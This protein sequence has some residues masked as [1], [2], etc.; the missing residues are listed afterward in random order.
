MEHE[1]SMNYYSL[2]TEEILKIL[3][4]DRNGLS[5]KEIP[6]RIERFGY[7]SIEQKKTFNYLFHI[8]QNLRSP[9][10]LILI[11]ATG[12][13][14]VLG[15]SI[16]GFVILFVLLVNLGIEIFHKRNA[17][18]DIELL[19]KGVVHMS[20][21][22]RDGVPQK[23]SSEEIVP[24]DIV[25]LEEGTMV[26]ADGRLIGVEHLSINESI[27]TGESLPVQK[28][29]RR[30]SGTLPISDMTNM[31]WFGTTVSQGSGTMLVTHTGF[32]TQFGGLKQELSTLLR[33]SNPFV[34]RIKQLS[35]TI[36]IIG[37]VVTLLIFA[38]R[39]GILGQSL[40]EI[41]IFS[42]AVLVSI[43]PESL[44]TVINIALLRGARHLAE[45][46]AVVKE[47]GSI[48][49]IGATT[50]IITDKT[51][52]LTENSMRVEYIMTRS[53]KDFSITGFGWKPVGMFL[54]KDH[55]FNPEDDEEL[56]T[57]LEFG[58][59][60]N[61]A[62]VYEENGIDIVVGEPTEASLLVLAEKAGIFRENLLK[63]YD[64]VLRTRFLHDKKVLIT[65]VKK[66]NQH[67]L[68]VIGAPE[69]IW[70]HSEPSIL[71]KTTTEDYAVLGLRTIAFAYA[72]L[73]KVP[74]EWDTL[75]PLSYLG[76]VAMRDPIRAGARESIERAREAGIRVIMATGDHKN[77]ARSIGQELGLVRRG[78]EEVM[79]GSE[80]LALNEKEQR[81]KVKTVN[82]FAR[83]TP[84]VKLLITKYLQKNK[85]VVTMIGDGV[86]DTLALRQADVGVAMGNSGTDAARSASSIVLTNDNFITVIS[87]IWSGRHITTNI[88]Q[89]T[90]FL[91]STNSAE[92]LVLIVAT[93]LG[94][95]LPL[96]AV[97]ILI[98]NLVTDGIGA[99]PFAFKKPN[100]SI[101]PRSRPGV[102]LSKNDYGIIGSATIGMTFATLIGFSIFLDFGLVYA[103]SA[104]FLILSLTQIGRLL[105]FG[106]Y[107]HSL[108]HFKGNPWLWRAIG[109]SCAIIFI[110]FTL[111]PLPALFGLEMLSFPHVLIAV[112]L[113]LLPIVTVEGYKALMKLSY[114][115]HY[116]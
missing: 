2:S 42:L 14:F 68:I 7:N 79:L 82:V 62:R 67:I 115:K 100:A 104:A 26:P 37:V 56:K 116:V 25:L 112:L 69:T 54:H 114:T 21:V 85:E 28:D 17:H 113:S 111:P 13:S 96:I 88:R 87:A 73:E 91:L 63:E 93:F 74:T 34:D 11:T 44:P 89:V 4:S 50:T 103:Q 84:E 24:G 38:I 65:V 22:L 9:F 101:V 35:K 52:T 61:R 36:G 39:F 20:T 90:N 108:F 10:S 66:D 31:A 32:K 97:Q 80:F 30:M 45:E 1:H 19:K 57:M 40:G 58:A 70:E 99:L 94:M 33:G 76:F 75:P 83:V 51:G 64:I 8:L 105:S 5:Q 15:H 110:V 59:L 98:I 77:T 48:E 72:K 12:L 46:H 6:E 41:A 102:L 78:F 23:K 86:N 71:S 3:N 18:R 107:Y 29:T 109:I 106:N 27:L 47:L 53:H 92:A 55:K 81:E 49:S 95:P 60:G 43:I 16:D